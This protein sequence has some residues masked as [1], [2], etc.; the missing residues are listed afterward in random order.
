M[1]FIGAFEHYSAARS[2]P[3]LCHG[4]TFWRAAGIYHQIELFFTHLTYTNCLDITVRQQLLMGF[5]AH[6]YHQLT[7]C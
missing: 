2:Y 7:A 5:A 4:K 3:S 6:N 1:T